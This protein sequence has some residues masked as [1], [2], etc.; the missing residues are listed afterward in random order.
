MKYLICYDIS[1]TKVRTK[2]AKSLQYF[3]LYRLQY[4]VFGGEIKEK[5]LRLLVSKLKK[6]SIEKGKDSILILPLKNKYT[7]LFSTSMKKVYD[8]EKIII[9]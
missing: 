5:H 3:G 8:E 9:I 7:E 4:S 6:M 1:E 2:I